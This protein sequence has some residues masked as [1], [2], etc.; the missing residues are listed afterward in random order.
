MR[1]L[2]KFCDALGINIAKLEH[3]T[4][5]GSVSGPDDPDARRRRS[6]DYTGADPESA[7]GLGI[8]AIGRPHVLAFMVAPLPFVVLWALGHAATL[9]LAV[10]VIAAGSVAGVIG[11]RGLLRYIWW[12]QMI[13]VEAGQPVDERAARQNKGKKTT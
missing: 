13:Q 8:S 5:P 6:A 3:R 11:L 7:D 1:G 9:Q 4:P 2:R 10:M 12:G